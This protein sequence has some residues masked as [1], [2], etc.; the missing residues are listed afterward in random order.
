MSKQ[1]TLALACLLLIACSTPVYKKAEGA[2]VAQI[3]LFNK[4]PS[5]MH[6]VLE[7]QRGNC[8]DMQIF[9]GNADSIKPGESRTT[10]AVPSDAFVINIVG[11]IKYSVGTEITFSHCSPLF[12]FKVE[13]NSQYDV[14]FTK[15]TTGCAIQVQR[16]I[17]KLREEVPIQK[18]KVKSGF[19]PQSCIPLEK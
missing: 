4:T 14:Y 17:G 1:F 5:E 15:T 16:L 7:S 8:T 2:N 10:P 9:G 18:F 12:G 3:R 19:G 11:N 6:Q 13:E